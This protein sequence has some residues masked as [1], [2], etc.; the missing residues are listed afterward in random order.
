M[1]NLMFEIAIGA[2]LIKRLPSV[3]SPC[4]RRIRM[5]RN[6]DPAT[7]PASV[8]WRAQGAVTAVRDQGSCGSCWAFS[9]AA[10]TEGAWQ[11]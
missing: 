2:H 9:A 1:I 11:M 4:A 8:D 10:A 6:F 5:P 7:L 3:N